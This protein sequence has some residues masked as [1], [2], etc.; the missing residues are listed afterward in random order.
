MRLYGSDGKVHRSEW[1]E[2]LD[3]EKGLQMG[4]YR[5]YQYDEQGNLI[6]EAY[7]FAK[8][9]HKNQYRKSG[10]PY[11]IHPINVAI[12]LAD[13]HVMP[14]TICAGIL[15]D[16]VEDTDTT[17]EELTSLFGEDRRSGLYSRC[18]RKT[19]RSS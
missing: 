2:G 15:H 17:L 19:C 16:T 11:I 8:E 10:E 4:S 12:I 18:N 9:K 6:E 7:L 13:L 1:V 3:R 14:N 5:D